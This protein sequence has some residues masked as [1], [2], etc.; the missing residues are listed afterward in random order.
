MNWPQLR[1]NPFADLSATQLRQNRS[2][3]WIWA[4]YPPFGSHVSPYNIAAS[5]IKELCKDQQTK[6]N[7]RELVELPI[8][9]LS[10]LQ[11]SYNVD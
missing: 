1:L 7:E 2:P 3:F 6:L 4:R 10:G 11:D 8:L 5:L 9:S